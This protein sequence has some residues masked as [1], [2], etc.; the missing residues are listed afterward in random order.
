MVLPHRVRPVIR[1]AKKPTA[2]IDEDAVVSFPSIKLKSKLAVGTLVLRVWGEL[3][4]SVKMICPPS[5]I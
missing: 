5:S 2:R 1:A 4:S 3:A